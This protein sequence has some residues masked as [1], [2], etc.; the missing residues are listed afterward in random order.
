MGRKLKARLMME[1]KKNKGNGTLKGEGKKVK[2][3]LF[4]FGEG[5]N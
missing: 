4:F 1:R 2:I 3:M 5:K